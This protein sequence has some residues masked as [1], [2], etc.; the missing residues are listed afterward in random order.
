[1]KRGG[2]ERTGV[3]SQ[4]KREGRRQKAEEENKYKT[5]STGITDT[6]TP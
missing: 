6:I 5:I 1:M 2:I 4:E 3:R